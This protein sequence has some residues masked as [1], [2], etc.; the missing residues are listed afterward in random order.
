MFGRSLFER[1]VLLGHTK[2]LL[3]VQYRMHPSIS[4]FP[5]RKFY[6]KQILDGPNVKERTYEKRFLK[7]NMYGPFSFINVTNWKEDQDNGFSRK[8][9]LEVAVVAEIVAS[10]FKGTFL[11]FKLFFNH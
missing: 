1:L 2:H 7:G 10:L 9:M 4:S 11:S 5:N 3:N 6:G 8:N